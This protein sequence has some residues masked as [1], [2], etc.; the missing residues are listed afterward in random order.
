MIKYLFLPCHASQEKHLSENL[1][2]KKLKPK[3]KELIIYFLPT[4]LLNNKIIKKLNKK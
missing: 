3:Q 4:F 2:H 1:L